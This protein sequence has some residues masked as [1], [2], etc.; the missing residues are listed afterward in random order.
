MLNRFIDIERLIHSTKTA[1]ACVIG[2]FLFNLIGIPAAQWIVIT[3]IVVMCAQI[4]VGSVMQKSYLRFLGTLIGCLFAAFTLTVAG[5]SK[6]A[7][8]VTVTLSSF[9]FSYIATGRENLTYTGTLGAVTTAIIML[10]V[11][12]TLFVAT[13]RFLEI[14]AGILIAAIVSQFILPIHASTH[15][16]RAQAKTLEQ[17]RDYYIR[18]MINH[19]PGEQDQDYQELDEN[20]VKS[21]LKQRQLA[22]ESRS[23]PLGS[24]FDPTH[25]M[26]SLYCEREMPRAITFMHNAISHVKKAAVIFH[27]MP[28]SHQF[29]ETIIQSLNTLIA[30]IAAEEAPQDHIHIP[31]LEPLKEEL[32][33]HIEAPTR[34]ELIYVD[35]LLF[36]A[37]VLLNS[38]ARLAALYHVNIYEA[39]N[40]APA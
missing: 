6:L 37:E 17:L 39:G 10:N 34:E 3:V 21:L 40:Q 1:I 32:Q 36:C 23:E 12:P 22:K 33:K 24:D 27:Q 29:N 14:S 31:S 25:F 8:M 9:V 35:G 13:Q 5:S 4:Y 30:V 7:I 19:Q 2:I 18:S 38:L 11:Q 28:G 16:R 20:I 15:L 26:Q